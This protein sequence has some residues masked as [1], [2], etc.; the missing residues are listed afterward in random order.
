MITSIIGA[1]NIKSYVLS[2]I[3][4]VG[5]SVFQMGPWHNMWKIRWLR[6]SKFHSA[7]CCH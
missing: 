7:F 1:Q 2:D 3:N 4:Q 5:S 6:G